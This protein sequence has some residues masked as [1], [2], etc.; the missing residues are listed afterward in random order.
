MNSKQKRKYRLKVKVFATLHEQ[1]KTA[2][3]ENSE[4]IVTKKFDP[5]S[6]KPAKEKEDEKHTFVKTTLQA[7]NLIFNI[8]EHDNVIWLKLHLKNRNFNNTTKKS[9][10]VI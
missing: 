5:S 6:I 9:N 4:F 2:P 7:I 10:Q 8:I 1:T 3:Q